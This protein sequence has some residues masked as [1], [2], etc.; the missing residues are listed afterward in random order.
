MR[1]VSV[2]KSAVFI[3]TLP[4]RIPVVAGGAVLLGIHTFL[5]RNVTYRTETKTFTKTFDALVEK[6]RFAVEDKHGRAKILKYKVKKLEKYE[7]KLEGFN[8]RLGN[9][10]RNINTAKLKISEFKVKN[11]FNKEKLAYYSNMKNKERLCVQGNKKVEGWEGVEDAPQWR[12]QA[13][14]ATS[15]VNSE[16]SR[17]SSRIASL[18]PMP[19]R[20]SR[21]LSVISK[22][23]AISNKSQSSVGDGKKRHSTNLVSG[24]REKDE[25]RIKNKLHKKRLVARKVKHYEGEIKKTEEQLTKWNSEL[26][27]FQGNLEVERQRQLKA[28]KEENGITEIDYLRKEVALNHKV[29]EI[30]KKRKEKALDEV[31]EHLK[32]LEE[33]SRNQTAVSRIF[34]GSIDIR[35]YETKVENA[36]VKPHWQ[37]KDVTTWHKARGGKRFESVV[38]K[39]RDPGNV[40]I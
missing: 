26:D 14:E 35:S 31:T 36:N 40:N 3:A 9:F 32:K 29:L 20:L 10:E 22:F 18:F 39:L 25:L 8:P 27:K 12:G 16:I 2:V 11:E 33:Y 37:Q 23:S 4:V 7:E 30:E 28:F 21:K 6:L 34:G 38:E 24:D 1:P 17:K 15:C 13:D 5:D 19:K